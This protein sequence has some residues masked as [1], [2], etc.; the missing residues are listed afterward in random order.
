MQKK[1]GQTKLGADV[2]ND[3]KHNKSSAFTREEREQFKLRGLLP[4]S[5]S[6][7][8]KQVQRFLYN[9]SKKDLDI[10]RYISLSNLQ[11][12]NERLFYKVITENI[13]ELL[14]IIYTPTVGQ[15]CKEFGHIF[16]KAKGFYI[17][18][19]DKGSIRRILDNWHQDDIRI[20]VV[21]DGERILGLGDL[22]A[23]GM[24]IPVGKCALY[25]ACGGVDPKYCLP[26]MLDVGT[27]NEDLLNSP[28]YL[29]YPHKRIT[30]SEY[31]ELVDEFIEAVKDK[32]PKALVQFEDFQTPNAVRFLEK[33][34]NELLCFNDD[35]QGTAAVA[36]A[37][38]YSAI[39]V[40]RQKLKNLKIMF[41]GAGSA[42]TG[43]AS[44][45]E[46]AL[47]KE[48]LSQEEARQHLYF[49]D[50]HGLL[51]ENRDNLQAHNE[52]YAQN[53]KEMDFM[54]ALDEI[55]PNLLI[56]ATGVG[57]AFNKEVIQKMAS[58]NET[59]IVFALSNPTSNAECTAEQAYKWTNGKLLFASGSPFD[60]VTLNG[61]VHKTGQGNNA[62]IF[63][64][65]GLGAALCR[66][67]N[68]PE[69]IF[70]VSARAL[71]DMLL[72]EDVR[73]GALFPPITR[74]RQISHR[75]AVDCIK[76]FQRLGLAQKELPE[77]LEEYVS[78]IMHDPSY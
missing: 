28:F 36:L 10:E 29:G 34:R 39:N 27:N 68:I 52:K 78:A 31:D 37:G 42:A 9:L 61:N 14:P 33:Y 15:A 59:P 18:P 53:K 12:R 64:G 21:T 2:L 56:G 50:K 8:E 32:Y 72:T 77:N 20:I 30:G 41:L 54:T 25:V 44:L 22:G 23:N 63:P 57:G 5:I 43:I 49:V 67:K 26:V 11:D 1:H 73:Q 55:Q 35:I 51:I 40:T 48:G 47:Q 16:R 65:L 71:S 19:E 7:Q 6:S 76:E 66:A 3:P 46:F 58:F 17:T 74:I 4:Y 69:E 62:Y 60:P 70:E 45:I 13:E 75:I 38:V 24:G